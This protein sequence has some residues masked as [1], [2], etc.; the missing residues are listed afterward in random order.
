MSDKLFKIN[1]LQVNAF[2]NAGVPY[3]SNAGDGS[4]SITSGTPSS[5]L[6]I[7]SSGV[8]TEDSTVYAPARITTGNTVNVD[9]TAVPS[10]YLV[11]SSVYKYK[12]IQCTN[13]TGT[14]ALGKVILPNDTNDSGF[15]IGDWFEIINFDNNLTFVQFFA[16]TGVTYYAITGAN[17]Y[18][19][20]KYSMVLCTKI[21][22]NTWLIEGDIIGNL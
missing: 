8:L 11:Q 5:F 12:R 19:R 3:I 20:T 15:A 21:A 6:K 22:S 4:V 7:D 14:A 2:S 17:V 9:P 13:S 18:L 16:D 1:N 10:G